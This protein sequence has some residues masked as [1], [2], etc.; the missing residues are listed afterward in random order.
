V[1]LEKGIGELIIEL[2]II[3]FFE[4]PEIQVKRISGKFVAEPEHCPPTK[5]KGSEKTL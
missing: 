1:V 3:L 2:I 5:G 4:K